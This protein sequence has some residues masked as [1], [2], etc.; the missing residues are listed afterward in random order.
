[1]MS[2]Q[3]RIV[4]ALLAALALV[5]GAWRIH[6][7]ADSAGYARA[8]AEQA[9]AALQALQERR[10]QELALG[11]AHQKVLDAHAQEKT[12]LAAAAAA[13]AHRLRGLQAALGASPSADAATAAR[14]ASAAR[15]V[16]G[17]CAAALAALDEHAANLAARLTALQAHNRAMQ[18]TEPASY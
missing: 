6:H 17:E 5:A 1:M 4:A 8:Q 10:A 13:T 12:R 7:K 11:L 16:A 14:A 3:A 9:Q 15:A 18:L 2:S